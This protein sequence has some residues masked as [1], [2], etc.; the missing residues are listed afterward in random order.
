M[1]ESLSSNATVAKIR[2]IEGKMLTESR[3]HELIYKKSVGEAAEFLKGV[4]RFKTDLET[5]DPA[6][7]HRGHLEELVEKSS[8]ELYRRLCRFQQFD[9]IPF[10][11]F[12]M[13]RHETEQILS[14][15]N[16]INSGVVHSFINTLPGF[17]LE[18][19]R[20]PFLEISKCESYE[21]LLEVL[22]KTD[23]GKVLKG[24]PLKE[25]GSINYPACELELRKYYFNKIFAS[26]RRDFPGKDAEILDKY[27]RMNIDFIN[28]VNAF[29]LKKYFNYN[30]EH[31]KQR[32]LPFS[33]ISKSKMNR[34]YECETAED[35]LD[36]LKKLPL[37]KDGVSA[38]M[39]ET[40]CDKARYS[41]ARRLLRSSQSAPVVMYA[42]MTICNFETGNIIKII[43]GIRYGLPPAEIEKLIII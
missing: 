4:P 16:C 13:F 24:I 40:A 43:E 31:I 25:D 32:M 42:F 38:Q 36:K 28:I 22:K 27:I 8:F 30:A 12:I 17:V 35:M 41:L 18:N 1:L 21:Q 9:K 34:L 6:T 33:S 2:C 37:L 15:I 23:Y 10:Y 11:N 19:S 3:L 39:I 20:L 29:R 14:M 7:I 5:V 26:V